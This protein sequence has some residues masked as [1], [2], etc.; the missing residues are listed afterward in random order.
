MRIIHM[1]QLI[2][3]TAA[4][5]SS[6]PAIAQSGQTVDAQSQPRAPQRSENQQPASKAVPFPLQLEMRVPFEPTAF[7]NGARMHLLYELHLTNFANS[8]LYVSRIDVIDADAPAAEPPIPP[9]MSN[10]DW[11]KSSAKVRFCPA[12]GMAE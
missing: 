1:R 12:T 5:I 2:L 3:F 8:A 11:A 10:V 6:C 9:A 7:P 4:V